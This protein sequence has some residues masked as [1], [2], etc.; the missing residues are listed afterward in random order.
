MSEQDITNGI[1]NMVKVSG[2]SGEGKAVKKSPVK[3]APK[4][5]KTQ[6][7]KATVSKAVVTPEV[8]SAVEAVQP[9]LVTAAAP[10]V[11]G[12]EMKTKDLIDKVVKRA[13]VKKKD[14]KPVVEAML[15]VLGEALGEGR[16][17][18]LQPLGRIKVTRVK[19]T[20]NGRVMICRVRQ[21]G[22]GGKG[23]K[24]ALAEDDD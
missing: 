18:V 9:K 16:E 11:A 15:A 4:S 5:A 8:A 6:A 14:V 3:A 24:E 10:V 23:R 7:P 12:P 22:G 17:L 2:A 20:G 13:G 19:E 21:G 1:K